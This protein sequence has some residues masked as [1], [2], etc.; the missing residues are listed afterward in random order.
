M[1][2]LSVPGLLTKFSDIIP[3]TKTLIVISNINVNIDKLYDAFE[4]TPYTI[5]KKTRGR[6][7]K[8][9]DVQVDPNEEI[10]EGSI[11]S[12]E[13]NSKH[14]G[15]LLKKNKKSHFRNALTINI[16][17]QKKRVN[18]KL[19]QNGKFQMTGCKTDTQAEDTIRILW[20]LISKDPTA[21]SF[22]DSEANNEFQITF[23]PVLRNISINL[24]FNV[25]Q[26]KLDRYLNTL[27]DCRSLYEPSIGYTGINMKLIPKRSILETKLKHL[28]YKGG[29][30]SEPKY[31]PYKSYLDLL[32]EKEQKKKT[33][34]VYR[35]TFLI[36]QS[37]I[38]IMSMSSA[39]LGEE[40]YYT[41]LEHIRNGM[42]L[43]RE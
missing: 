24:G 42:H 29:G 36:F 1:S 8:E 16:F 33:E 14:R 15:V 39:E 17:V 7:K 3:S 30:W 4:I 11:I 6:K 43:F 35:N 28:V 25:N 22:K 26:E 5:V 27:P 41:F 19:C 12:I 9:D 10:Q 38:A 20:Q 32:P 21:Y 37:G 13:Y 31:L 23:V 34:K 2:N 18:V 40:T